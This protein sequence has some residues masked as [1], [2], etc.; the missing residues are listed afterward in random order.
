ML[1]DRFR[2]TYADSRQKQDTSYVRWLMMPRIFAVTF[3]AVLI[4]ACGSLPRYDAAFSD[5][6]QNLDD[7]IEWREFKTHFPD[8]D[9]KAFLEADRNK[10]GEITSDEWDVF[11]K[12]QSP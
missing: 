11:M 8:A 12:T 10:N 7:V 6:D 4:M 3:M 1:A 9:P 5:V 2:M